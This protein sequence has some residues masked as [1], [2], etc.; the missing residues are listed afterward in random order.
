MPTFPSPP[1]KFRTAGFPRYGLKAGISDETFPVNWF[2]FVLRALGGHRE[3]LRCG[4][5]DGAGE[6]LRASGFPLYPRASL[7]TGLCYPDPSSLNWPHPT[8]SRAHPDFAAWRLIRDAFAVPTLHRPRRPTTGSELSLMLF[9]N[10][11][12]STTTGNSSAAFAQYFTEDTSLQLRMKVS[13][14]PSSSHSGSDEG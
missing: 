4:R 5:D 10:M 7:R 6:H 1:L 11:S 14:F 9:H 2:V 3:F 8:H 13:A 12:P